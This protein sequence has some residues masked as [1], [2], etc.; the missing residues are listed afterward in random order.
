MR[1]WQNNNDKKF[2]IACDLSHKSYL[3]SFK[4]AGRAL[5]RIVQEVQRMLNLTKTLILRETSSF[6]ALKN[7]LLK[8]YTTGL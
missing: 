7:A 3:L 8:G 6:Y 1:Y 2:W 4:I 5:N